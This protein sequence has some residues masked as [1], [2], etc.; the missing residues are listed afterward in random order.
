MPIRLKGYG[1]NQKKR[2]EYIKQSGLLLTGV[3]VRKA[4]H[5]AC[6]GTLESVK[7]VPGCSGSPL[8]GGG[9][10]HCEWINKIDKL[11]RSCYCNTK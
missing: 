11:Y 2:K 4:K 5:E 10:K 3:D 9:Y 8:K 6:I 7:W 1:I